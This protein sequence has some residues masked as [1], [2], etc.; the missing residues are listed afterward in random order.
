MSW[1]YHTRTA[2]EDHKLPVIDI[3]VDLLDRRERRA[4]P[5]IRIGLDQVFDLYGTFA[6]DF[7]L[8]G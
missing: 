7:L 5:I 1:F 4:T 2:D 8:W 6:H 3:Q